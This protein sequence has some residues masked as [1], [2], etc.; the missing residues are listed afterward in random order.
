MLKLQWNVLLC[1][2][3][4]LIPLI[5]AF[6]PDEVQI[7]QLQQEIEKTYGADLDLYQLLKLP[8]LRESS[9]LEI[10]K[11][12]RKLSKT[13]HP[14]KNKKYKKLYERLNLATKILI[15][16]SQRKVYDYYLKNGFP[17]YDFKKGGFYFTRVQPKVWVISS[18]VYLACGF[19]HFIIL[20]LQNDGNKARIERFLREVKT[21]DDTNGLGEKRLLLKQNP[22]EEG[23]QLVVKLGEVFVVQP[24]GSEA[25]ISTQDIKNPG[26]ADCLL[27]TLPLWVWNKSIGRMVSKPKPSG[28]KGVSEEPK[29]S[30]SETKKNKSSRASRGSDKMELPNGKIV[31]SRKKKQ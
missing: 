30:S 6:T 25:L 29:H 26:I 15:D 28:D 22:K 13:Y 16:E 14:D 1:C 12:F 20:R 17:K 9:S 21:Q 24:D 5:A 4:G 3:L 19:I 10:R 27:V 8:K 23:K 31:Q 18:L 2:L 7:F 11:N